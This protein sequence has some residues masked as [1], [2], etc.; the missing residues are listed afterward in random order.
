MTDTFF[1]KNFISD[2]N[3]L[4]KQQQVINN[5][6]HSSHIR[7]SFSSDKDVEMSIAYGN[8]IHVYQIKKTITLNRKKV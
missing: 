7:N 1:N 4:K 3:K 5:S 8:N 2:W 6:W